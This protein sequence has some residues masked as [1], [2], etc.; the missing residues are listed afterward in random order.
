MWL[1]GMKLQNAMRLPKASIVR[2][3]KTGRTITST[4]I[5]D[6]GARISQQDVFG[7]EPGE[8]F[9]LAD[10]V[11]GLPHGDIAAK[12]AI[13]TALWAY[14]S[15]KLKPYAW[16]DRR[17]LVNRI[18]KSADRAIR[19]KAREFNGEE[20]ATT[21]LVVVVGGFKIHV[22][23]VGDTVAYLWHN[24]TVQLLTKRDR[25]TA[26]VLTKALGIGEDFPVPS[27]TVLDHEP[28]DAFLLLTDGIADWVTEDEL[29]EACTNTS[30]TSDHQILEYLVKV[31]VDQG[32]LDNMT[33]GII[34]V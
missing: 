19:V 21:L 14:T 16:K 29:F 32:S 11:G 17:L 23:S 30:F 20:L 15:S 1:I 5:T 10:G 34:R 2:Q 12:T 8:C 26:N 6:R 13:D 24:K 7:E 25:Q 18:F 22:G 4:W 31:A 3:P 9:F 28:G 27:I 33:G